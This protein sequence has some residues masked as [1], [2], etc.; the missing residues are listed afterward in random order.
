MVADQPYMEA[1]TKL[2]ST[3]NPDKLYAAAIKFAQDNHMPLVID[4]GF[5]ECPGRQAREAM[6]RSPDFDMTSEGLLATMTQGQKEEF[7][8]YTLG[9]NQI[10]LVRMNS[11]Q[12]F[13]HFQDF[14]E[15]IGAQTVVQGLGWHKVW[16]P[17]FMV[18]DPRTESL[19]AND[20]FAGY[21]YCTLI[22]EITAGL[23][24]IGI[25]PR[26]IFRLR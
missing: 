5:D 20:W 13:Q 23:E 7:N 14:A 15:R 1:I 21:R 11:H 9:R 25:A 17:L 16:S 18:A 19:A 12:S 6:L 3:P 4:W 2:A 10:A 8:T 22:E 26:D 24:Q